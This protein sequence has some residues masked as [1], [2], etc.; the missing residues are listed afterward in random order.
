MSATNMQMTEN[1]L[2]RAAG[3]MNAAIAGRLESGRLESG[4]GVSYAWLL[5]SLSDGLFGKPYGEV[6]STLLAS[7]VEATHGEEEGSNAAPQ[8]MLLEH[9]NELILAVNEEYV[10][11]SFPG[12]DMDLPLSVLR[13]QAET[14]AGL[15][16]ST[17]GF[18]TL[19]ELLG[20]AWETDDI[21][22]L[23]A[24]L[25]YFTYRTPLHE[26][27][28]QGPLVIFRNAAERWVL[29]G[30]YQEA[31]VGAVEDGKPWRDALRAEIVWS[32]TFQVG[33]DV[34]DLCFT[35]QDLGQAKEASPGVWV[36]H[37]E[38]SGQDFEF[39]LIFKG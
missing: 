37:E 36:V 32:P 2:K 9:R 17:V 20:E 6:R 12:T 19:P 28:D 35:L 29:D 16:G 4:R 3:R 39:T 13:S 15:C 18:V 34:F 22:D 10:T 21:I 1:Q 38:A 30:E 26:Q 11:V 8:V 5:E 24:S 7:P 27:I 14:L 23:A 25:G 33:F 31:I